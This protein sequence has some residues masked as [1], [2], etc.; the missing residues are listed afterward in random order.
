MANTIINASDLDLSILGYATKKTNE[1]GGSS[2]GILNKSIRGSLRMQTPMMLTW[3]ASDYVD[4]KTGESDGKYYVYP[5][6]LRD[7]EV[8]NDYGD[9]AWSE[10]YKRG[11]Y[12]EFNS[13]E[14]ADWFSQNY[15]NVWPKAMR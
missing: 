9:G 14:D 1:R 11:E 4:Q 8:L 13:A 10:A 7:G 12:I 2:M 3:G 5:T 15:K 6:V